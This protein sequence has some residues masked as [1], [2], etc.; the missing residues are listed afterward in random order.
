M[1]SNLDFE[2][3]L[4]NILNDN[5]FTSEE[6]NEEIMKIENN[7]RSDENIDILD[8]NEQTSQLSVVP[9]FRQIPDYKG[10]NDLETNRLSELLS[11]TNVFKYPLSTKNIIK[12]TNFSEGMRLGFVIFD[13]YV[14]NLIK[15]TKNINPFIDLC[16]N[17]R[18]ALLKYGCMDLIVMRDILHYSQDIKYYSINLV[19]DFNIYSHL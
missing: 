18:I 12:I 9:L 4:N 13:K 10:F 2:K 17:D 3:F 6:I 1:D 7:I 16:E 19:I 11:A 15:F 14:K 5:C 8:T